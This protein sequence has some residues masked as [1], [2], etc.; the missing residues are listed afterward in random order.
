M[1]YGN[2]GMLETLQLQRNRSAQLRAQ[3]WASRAAT[4]ARRNPDEPRNPGLRK[5][6]PL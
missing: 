5:M 2:R 1:T 3:R 4:L 6:A